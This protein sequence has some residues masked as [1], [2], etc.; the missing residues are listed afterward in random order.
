M[1]RREIN[2]HRCFS[3]PLYHLL[4]GE[5]QAPLMSCQQQHDVVITHVAA[6]SKLRDRDRA[7]V[8]MRATTSPSVGTSIATMLG[9]HTP[10]RP[11]IRC[12]AEV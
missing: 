9:G 6:H 12:A 3:T 8:D 11:S 2:Y 4:K 5:A 1:K 7:F 10:M